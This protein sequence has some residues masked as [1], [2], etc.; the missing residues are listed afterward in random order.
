LTTSIIWGATLEL[1]YLPGIGSVYPLR[2]ILIL[3]FAYE[4]ANLLRSHKSVCIHNLL[5][6]TN[7]TL[8]LFWICLI[9]ATLFGVK[10][11]NTMS[12]FI[13]YSMNILLISAVVSAVQKEE[14]RMM[15]LKTIVLNAVIIGVMACYENINGVWLFR[16]VGASIY[17]YNQY[18]TLTPVCIFFNTNNLCMF[19][20]LSMIAFF[21]ICKIGIF[22]ILY[23]GFIIWL[24]EVSS[25]RTGI[26]A[27]VLSMIIYVSI[28]IIKDVRAKV[29]LYTSYILCAFVYLTGDNVLLT[30]IRLKIW[31]NAIYNAYLNKFM[32]LGAG[33]AIYVNSNNVLYITLQT[34]RGAL[35]AIHNYALELLI[36][37]GLMGIIILGYWLRG[38]IKIVWK[39]RASDIGIFYVILF[40][41][42]ILTSMCVSSMTDY[43]QYWIFLG[44]IIS[45]AREI[46]SKLS[47]DGI[48]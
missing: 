32:G 2:I 26:L 35:S 38:I 1:F 25:C 3:Y 34:G 9:F 27:V 7:I 28:K 13:T 46:E 18:G 22:R 4:M 20:V 15:A 24:S 42:F 11:A 45:Y 23:V 40:V 33:S 41:I 44:L 16:K 21:M 14:E 43:F 36:E 6:K 31:A 39:N 8:F 5:V 19:M 12:S 10:R 29:L 17:D 37:I 47:Y 48:D 30:N